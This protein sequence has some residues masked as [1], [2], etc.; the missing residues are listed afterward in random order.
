VIILAS[1][2]QAGPMAA[3]V[4]AR[5]D[6]T[7]VICA[8]VASLGAELS[9]GAGALLVT[10]QA[11]SRGARRVRCRTRASDNCVLGHSDPPICAG[12][13]VNYQINRWVGVRADESIEESN[14]ARGFCIRPAATQLC[15]FLRRH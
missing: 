8:D 13:G 7:S 12:A 9:T 2:G 14:Q 3:E 15:T 10:G 11:L 5:A 4:L 6:N 1:L